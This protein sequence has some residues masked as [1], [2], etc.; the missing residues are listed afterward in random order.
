MKNFYLH[1]VCL[2]VLPLVAKG[3]KVKELLPSSEQEATQTKK[4]QVQ[5][6]TFVSDLR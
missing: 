1:S 4:E 2:L 6:K 5:T 3:T